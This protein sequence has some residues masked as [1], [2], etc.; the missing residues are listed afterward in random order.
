MKVKE[1]YHY[2]T[3]LSNWEGKIRN[4]MMNKSLYV[5]TTEF[6]K[7]QEIIATEKNEEK[8]II[9]KEIDYTLDDLI[10]LWDSII[11]EKKKIYAL[12]EKKKL[13][14]NMP[15]EIF[16]INKSYR[17]ILS[18]IKLIS[19]STKKS[20]TKRREEGFLKS[21]E[22]VGTYTY[23][24]EV[25]TTPIY[26]SSYFIEKLDKYQKIAEDNSN[27][28]DTFNTTVEIDYEPRWS[29]FSTIEDLLK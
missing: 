1:V 20:V 25:N 23:E 6:H 19:E 10:N 3:V 9:N 2:L 24:V 27:K 18:I 22:G 5:K 11:E 29:E 4:T 12:I 17:E 15:D 21:N 7:K 13:E 26:E 14:N 28:I 8:E 16:T